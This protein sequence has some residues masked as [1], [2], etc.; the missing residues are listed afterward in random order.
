MENKQENI[1]SEPT[2]EPKQDEPKSVVVSNKEKRSGKDE[3]SRKKEDKSI[4]YILKSLNG[5][6]TPEEKL[7]A[8]CKKY[9]E[10]VDEN[11]KLQMNLKQME[12]KII[13]TQREKEQCQSEKSKAVL[14]KSRLENLCR[15]L[16]RQN[17]AVKEESLLKIREEEEKRK[18]VSANF[19]ST[20][21]EIT[22]LW[23]ET[24][25]K[26]VKLHEDNIEIHKKFKSV[27]DEMDI[28]EQHFESMH[29]VMKQEL[30]VADAKLAK[31][32]LEMT[33][34]RENLLK[35]KNLLL[36]KLTE[37]QNKIKELHAVESNLRSQVQ[38]Y[39]EKY[40]EFQ[41]ALSKSNEIFGG[42]NAEMEKMSKKILKLEKD[43]NM[44]KTRWENSHAALLEMVTDKQT[45]D[46]EIVQLNKKCQLLQELCKAFQQ[47]RATLLV[48][49]KEKT[50]DPSIENIEAESTLNGL[51]AL[52]NVK[53]KTNDE[54]QIDNKTDETMSKADGSCTENNKE[55][56]PLSIDSK[57]ANKNGTVDTALEIVNNENEIKLIEIPVT[58]VVH[59]IIDEVSQQS[60]LNNENKPD[61]I[62]VP[63]EIQ[64]ESETSINEIPKSN[65]EQV[66][67]SLEVKNEVVKLLDKEK[68]T[69]VLVENEALN[70]EKDKSVV[71]NIDND[72][73]TKNQIESCNALIS[74]E[75]IQ[76]SV[77]HKKPKDS[78][79]KKK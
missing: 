78:K 22:T 20:L 70:D 7:F 18:E 27:F 6:N 9:N 23:A 1:E 56:K 50:I 8:V 73:T 68:A 55:I 54:Y 24:N 53:D 66:T 74:N 69:E 21:T 79:K 26:N 49:L 17:K 40:D 34:E 11:R 44:W 61:A 42:F 63:V 13:M 28:R 65:S 2:V 32:N 43:N 14:A 60:N 64:N 30:Q 59:S 5:L 16:Q 75:D 25:D 48:E 71:P 62:Q 52:N 67:E 3:K 37:Y 38:M 35:E 77:S 72:S 76:N 33:E 31:M 15:E 57:E 47:E 12:K 4:E 10:I 19:Q 29:Q 39:T 36:L 45:R 41:N 58:E 51:P 46:A